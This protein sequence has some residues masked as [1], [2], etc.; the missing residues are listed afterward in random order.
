MP[1]SERFVIRGAECRREFSSS[2]FAIKSI[3]RVQGWN[4]C[5]RP[6]GWIPS[7]SWRITGMTNVGIQK[8]RPEPSLL[9]VLVRLL[10]LFDCSTGATSQEAATR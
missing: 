3:G 8:T 5:V 6:T 2:A 4:P 9:F 10:L 1:A 7:A